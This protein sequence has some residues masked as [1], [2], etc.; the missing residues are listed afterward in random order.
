MTGMADTSNLSPIPVP[1]TCQHPGCGAPI[2]YEG[3]G[4][5][6][7]DGRPIAGHVVDLGA[8]YRDAQRALFEALKAR[9]RTRQP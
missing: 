2:R 8:E 9:A 3:F 5:V 6:H 1:T 4:Y 7:N